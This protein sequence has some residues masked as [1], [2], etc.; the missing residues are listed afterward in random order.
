M[1][2]IIVA[3]KVH[4]E[5]PLLIAAN[6]DESH[7][8]PTRQAEY[9]VNEP[10]IL[11]GHDLEEGG[12]WLGMNKYG[13]IAA[14]TNYRS[15][16]KLKS[17]NTSRGLLVSEYLK[18]KKPS[19]SYLDSCLAN[20]A[21]FDAFNLLL[22]DVNGLYFLN[23][24]EKTYTQLQAGFYGISN[25]DF[26]SNWPKVKRAKQQIH[27]LLKADQLDSHEAILTTLTDK[28]LPDDESLPDTGVGIE[29]ERALAPIFIT[30]KD[31]GTRSS[32][33]VSVNK[34]DKVRF[35][36]RSYDRFGDIE[37]TRQFEF[38]IEERK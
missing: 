17:S 34:N 31:Y 9:W 33:V 18:Y 7:Q 12:S 6:R 28:Y 11:A 16:A 21:D 27:D 8:R 10:S 20:L 19:R 26:D 23:S 13:R 3:Y 37:N 1:C 38:M 25:G 22:G 2:L 14:V 35:T 29:W 15:G 30:A 36:E 5:Y 32:S 4:P 24:R